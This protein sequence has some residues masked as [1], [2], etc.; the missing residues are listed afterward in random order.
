MS[1]LYPRSQPSPRRK[2]ER[3]QTTRWKEQKSGRKN[4]G[5]KRLDFRKARKNIGNIKNKNIT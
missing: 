3:E 5:R 2:E 1:L 4:K